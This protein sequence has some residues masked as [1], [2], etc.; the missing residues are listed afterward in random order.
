MTFKYAHSM[1]LFTFMLCSHCALFV[2]YHSILVWIMHFHFVL[3][4]GRNISNLHYN[5]RYIWK[6]AIEKLT[7]CLRHCGA[8]T[9]E[10]HK[11]S[12]D[13][14]T[15]AVSLSFTLLP[16]LLSCACSYRTS[17]VSICLWPP[18]IHQFPSLEQVS[19]SFQ[20]L[21]QPTYSPWKMENSESPHW[22]FHYFFQCYME[23]AA[24]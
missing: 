22:G 21:S 7:L 4:W 15:G 2:S 3:T 6:N 9:L 13:P 11:S 18:A 16:R 23:G 1:H 5:A 10:R 24:M 20:A 8:T 17:W 14:A 19:K 12:K